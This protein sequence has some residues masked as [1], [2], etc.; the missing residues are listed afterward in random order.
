VF[1]FARRMCGDIGSASPCRTQG[2]LSPNIAF[3]GLAEVFE[4][5]EFKRFQ[6]RDR[7]VCVDSVT[8][9]FTP[10]PHPIAVG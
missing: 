6:V 3:K 7:C 1:T 5:A 4:P 10:L 8:S 2:K 9:V